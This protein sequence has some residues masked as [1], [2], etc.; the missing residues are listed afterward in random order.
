MSVEPRAGKASIKERGEYVFA[1]RGP[2]DDLEDIIKLVNEL[3]AVLPTEWTLHASHDRAEIDQIGN[4]NDLRLVLK[5]EENDDEHLAAAITEQLKGESVH[6]KINNKNTKTKN[7]PRGTITLREPKKFEGNQNIL[8]VTKSA[9]VWD[10]K[11]ETIMEQSRAHLGSS[12]SD[13]RSLC[14][15]EH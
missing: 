6:R 11:R 15:L 13:I 8:R 1:R 4:E 2:R 3:G 7:F 10:F 12:S 14:R 5:A 9:I